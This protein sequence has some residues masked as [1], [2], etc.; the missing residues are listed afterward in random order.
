MGSI[1]TTTAKTSVISLNGVLVL[2]HSF[3]IRIPMWN[4]Y[5]LYICVHL[6]E[7]VISKASIAKH[8]RDYFSMI[9]R[10]TTL[11]HN[12]VIQNLLWQL[13]L[14]VA[15]HK[16]LDIS[17]GLYP[18]TSD[19]VKYSDDKTIFVILTATDFWLPT[20]YEI[21]TWPCVWFAI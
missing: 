16:E 18:T 21:S 4:E 11:F 3:G 10:L 7:K 1:F 6:R 20:M 17:D 13:K 5:L 14:P 2:K 12:R 15:L 8:T 9:P 19:I